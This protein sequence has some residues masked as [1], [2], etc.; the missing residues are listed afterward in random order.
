MTI[1]RWKSAYMSYKGNH[2]QAAERFRWVCRSRKLPDRQR[3]AA[4]HGLPCWRSLLFFAG[5][6]LLCRSTGSGGKRFRSVMSS[7]STGR[8]LPL[9]WRSMTLLRSVL[10]ISWRFSFGLTG[11]IP[12]S[13]LFSGTPT[14]S[15]FCHGHLSAL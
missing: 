6:I 10:R 7:L 1:Y 5:G 12:R 14:D 13:L 4:G 9:H 15:L 2:R 11:P 3:L 8:W